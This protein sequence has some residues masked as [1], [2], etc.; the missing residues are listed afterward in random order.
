[1]ALAA[2][3]YRIFSD[4]AINRTNA[5]TRIGPKIDRNRFVMGRPGRFSMVCGDIFASYKVTN[6][7]GG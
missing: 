4:E 1:M 5:A 6:Y 3:V 2:G 7:T